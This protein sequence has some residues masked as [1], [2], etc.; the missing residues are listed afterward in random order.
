VPPAAPVAIATPGGAVPRTPNGGGV[1]LPTYVPITAVK[2]DLPGN[3]TVPD[4]YLQFPRATFKSV[5]DKP[6]AG[7]D[8]SWMTYTIVPNAA[9]DDNPAWQEVNAQVGANLRMQLT[10]FADYN[11]R[12]QT[13]LAG[14]DLPDVVFIQAL[15]PEQARLMASKFAD[16]TPYLSGDAVKEYPN[17]ANLPTISWKSTLFNNA[18]SAVPTAYMRFFWM[19]WARQE[20]LDAIGAPLPANADEFKRVLLELTRPQSGVWGIAGHTGA[21]TAPFDVYGTT[22]GALYATMF[23]APNQW[24]EVGGKFTRTWETEQ[25]KAAVAYARDLVAAGVYHPDSLNWNI[26]AK[27]TNFEAGKFAFEFDG[28][29]INLWNNARRVNPATRLRQPLPP[30][31]DGT[32]GH[33]WY[34]SGTF[35]ITAIKKASPERIKE[36]LRVMNFLAAPIGSEEYLLLHYGIRGTDWEFDANGNPTLTD[37]GQSDQMPWGAGTV[38][39]PNPPQIL[40]NP[41]DPEFARVIQAEQK[42]MDAVGESDPTIGLYSATNAA[43]G[44]QITQTMVDGLIEILRGNQPIA[45]LE[46]L[47]ADWRKNG[48]DQTRAE[49]EQAF[50]AQG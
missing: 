28:M 17:L 27:R 12:L 30:P 35:G 46:Q 10:P 26:L 45:S 22:G 15:Q 47:V 18:I 34:G 39:V 20:M 2:P 19:L 44:N 7:S 50:A 37:K 5:T 23:G 33:Y 36:I 31:A 25:F 49:Y 21:L 8:I 43:R 24:R 42:V 29:T 16:L 41:Q 1:K 11:A 6:G 14:D 38:T 32:S 40:F 4:G 3:E 13:V 48:G 9:L